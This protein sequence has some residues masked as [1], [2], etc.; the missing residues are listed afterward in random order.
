MTDSESSEGVATS[1]DASEGTSEPS[2]ESSGF[3][4][5]DEGDLPPDCS[6][7]EQDC[8][9]GEKCVPWIDPDGSPWLG[10]TCVP[11]LGE[12]GV[13]E[14]CTLDFEDSSDDCDA[15]SSCFSFS[16]FDG[17]GAGQCHAFCTGSGDDPMCP[18]SHTCLIGNGYPGPVLCIPQCDPLAQDCGEELGCYWFGSFFSCAA[19]NGAGPAEPCAVFTD[20][21]AGNVCVE[22]DRIPSCDRACC[23]IFCALSLGDVPCAELPGTSCQSYFQPGTAPPGYEDLGVCIAP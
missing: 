3:V 7:F 19:S 5:T 4:P 9:E 21:G 20:C 16:I 15:A 6:V 11:V 18:P 2:A 10:F 1:E 13:G 8:G 23:S 14:P 17:V 22:G 12:Q